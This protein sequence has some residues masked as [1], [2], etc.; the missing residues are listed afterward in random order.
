VKELTAQ[1]ASTAHFAAAEIKKLGT[2]R[3]MGSAVILELSVLGGRTV[4]PVAI[5]DGLS[6]ETIAALVNDL[7][8][9]YDIATIFKPK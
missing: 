2:D 6:P 1:L 5:R 7:K 3:I 4:H 9:S 8:R